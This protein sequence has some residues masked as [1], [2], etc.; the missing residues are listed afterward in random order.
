MRKH[1]F[2]LLGVGAAHSQL[3]VRNN[4]G[5]IKGAV[6]SVWKTRSEQTQCRGQQ[7]PGLRRV[8]RPNLSDQHGLI[9]R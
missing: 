4:R 5:G 8:S 3:A 2:S 6:R 1:T 7:E 9:L